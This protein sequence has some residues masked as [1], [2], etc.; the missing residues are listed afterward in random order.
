MNVPLKVTLECCCLP[1]CILTTVIWIGLL[2]HVLY[3]VIVCYCRPNVTGSSECGLK[4]L[5]P[6]KLPP[7]KCIFLKNILHLLFVALKPLQYTCKL[8]SHSE[9]F[10][11]LFW[12]W[13][14]LFMV[15]KC[16]KWSSFNNSLL[17]VIL[18][19]IQDF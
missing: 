17:I 11:V 3:C 18:F 1:L 10:L 6:N 19:N 15:S 4:P 7:F 8:Y 5:N 13:I 14:F 16:C 2:C 12:S 9:V